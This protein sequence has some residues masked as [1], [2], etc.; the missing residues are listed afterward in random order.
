VIHHGKCRALG[1]IKDEKAVMPLIEV[2]DNE[3]MI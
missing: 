2:L 3:I 1:R